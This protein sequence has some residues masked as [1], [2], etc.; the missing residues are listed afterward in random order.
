MEGQSTSLKQSPPWR[1]S[2]LPSLLVHQMIVSW[3]WCGMNKSAPLL[4]S[5]KGASDP[6]GMS[7]PWFSWWPGS[8]RE[9]R[10]VGVRCVRPQC[11]DSAGAAKVMTWLFYMLA[12]NRVLMIWWI[13]KMRSWA[14][15]LCFSMKK[16]LSALSSSAF[17]SDLP[18]LIYL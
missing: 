10:P 4:S 17:Q 1:K 9:D 14:S 11:G 5:S 18:I 6:G 8:G 13:L 2:N 7:D 15:D 16:I 12:V 3:Y